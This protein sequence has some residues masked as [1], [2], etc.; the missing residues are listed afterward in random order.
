MNDPDFLIGFGFFA[1]LPIPTLVLKFSCIFQR[2]EPCWKATRAL[3][4]VQFTMVEMFVT[5]LHFFGVWVTFSFDPLILL[6][7]FSFDSHRDWILN[8]LTEAE[9]F[10]G[11]CL[12]GTF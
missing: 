5:S 12:W 9:C 11:T 10:A 7:T 4:D 2:I 3:F 6:V 8:R 1:F